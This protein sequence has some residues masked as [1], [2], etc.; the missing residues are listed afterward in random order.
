M[1][2]PTR[3]LPAYHFASDVDGVRHLIVD[4]SDS[5]CT[6]WRIKVRERDGGY[7]F[8]FERSIVFGEDAG[9]NLIG[10][11]PARETWTVVM[12]W[13]AVSAEICLP[14]G[15]HHSVGGFIL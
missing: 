10:H 14:D 7:Q 8:P 12:D 6:G 15:S 3:A 1:H 4:D 2:E 11:G 13:G 9:A 5:D